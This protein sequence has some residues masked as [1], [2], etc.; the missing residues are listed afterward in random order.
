MGD[1]DSVRYAH[2]Q[3]NRSKNDQTRR[4]Q[5]SPFNIAAKILGPNEGVA[6]FGELF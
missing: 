4:P 3:K 2:M 6:T 5:I 1:L